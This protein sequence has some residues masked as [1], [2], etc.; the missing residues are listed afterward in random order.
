MTADK[1]CRGE[2][3]HIVTP[4][5]N[6]NDDIGSPVRG[7][8]ETVNKRFKQW[9]VLQRVFRHAVSEHQSAF[10]AIAVVTQLSLAREWGA[11]VCS[12]T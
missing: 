4:T 12:C 9:N 7:R 10:S 3:D 6:K 5:G 1:G 8:H 2:A 11:I